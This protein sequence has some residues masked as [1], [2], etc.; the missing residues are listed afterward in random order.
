MTDAAGAPR[1]RRFDPVVGSA[2]A[3]LSLLYLLYLLW[4]LAGGGAGLPTWL[5][6]LT[7]L[8]LIAG[9]AAYV[10]AIVVEIAII[11]RR[12]NETA[13]SAGERGSGGDAQPD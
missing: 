8:P 6:I 13:G 2:F 10:V 11:Y 12:R 9:L 1:K 4:L 3:I 7:M 5:I